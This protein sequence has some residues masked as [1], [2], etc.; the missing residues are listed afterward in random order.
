MEGKTLDSGME[1][2]HVGRV[3]SVGGRYALGRCSGTP[4][5]GRPGVPKHSK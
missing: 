5:I 1:N 3:V 2:G 4:R